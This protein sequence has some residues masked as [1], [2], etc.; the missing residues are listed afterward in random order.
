LAGVPELTRNADIKL[1]TRL[2]LRPIL[3]GL[4][5][6]QVVQIG[7]PSLTCVLRDQGSLHA[8]EAA[9]PPNIHRDRSG[10][11]PAFVETR[12]D[13]DRLFDPARQVGDVVTLIQNQ[14]EQN[15]PGLRS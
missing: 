13:P 15:G 11:N 1:N 10:D 3:A 6:P 12:S 4:A 9:P 8:L 2:S 14:S 5:W 7:P